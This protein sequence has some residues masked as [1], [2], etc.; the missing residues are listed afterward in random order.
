MTP[1]KGEGNERRRQR[2]GPFLCWAV[3]FADIGTSVYYT[4]GILFGHVGTRAALFVAMTMVVFVLLAIKYAEITVRYPEGGGVVTVGTRALHPYVGLVGGL[5]I[6]VDYFLTAALSALSGMIYLSVVFKTLEPAVVL[7]TVVALIVLAGLNLVGV[8]ASAEVTALFAVIAGVAQLAVVVAVVV[9]LGPTHLLDPVRGAMAG[10]PLNPTLVLTGFAGAFL[11]FS[12]LESISQLSPSMAEPRR[13]V[14]N[15]TMGLVVMTIA[16]TSPLLTLWSTTLVDTQHAD[17]NQFISLLG[18][19][20]AGPVLSWTVAISAALLLV[21]A[22]NTALI[23]SYH[24]FLALSR[25]QFLPQF[26]GQRNRWRGT[27]HWAILVAVGIPL[28]V[29][30]GSR[31]DVGL[32][33][34]LYAFGLLGAFVITSLSLDI[35]RWHERVARLVFVVGVITTA[36]VSLAWLTNLFAKPLA[37]LFGGALTTVGAVVAL[38]TQAGA[39][40]RGL[41]VVFPHLLRADREPTLIARAR[42]IGPCAVLAVLPDETTQ[43]VA[44]ANAAVNL[45]Q[46][47]PI[48]FL[49]RG[50]GTPPTGLPHLMEIVDPYLNDQHA[51][52]IFGRVEHAARDHG[53]HRKYVYVGKGLAADAVNRVWDALQPDDTLVVAGDDEDF[54]RI[55]TGGVHHMIQDSVPIL[56]YAKRPA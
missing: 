30:A 10:P 4:P 20:A 40:A 50:R 38:S 12:G 37:T 22:S 24:V 55:P 25:M 19:Y 5:F 36:A 13:R 7:A 21:F 32:L 1:H 56:D 34:D 8:K 47:R 51:Q 44:L 15:L 26:I 43:A 2:L 53:G 3:V 16:V 31:G 45:A 52:E 9:H 46:G 23:G 11:A 42:R 28:A 33:G 41:P 39:R 54:V 6:L 17:P 29:V 27:P 48:V 14:A 18:A 35:I 49:Y